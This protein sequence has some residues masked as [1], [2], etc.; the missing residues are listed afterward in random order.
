[1]SLQETAA[2]DFGDVITASP[3][4][5][6]HAKP[7]WFDLGP[8]PLTLRLLAIQVVL[9]GVIVALYQR[10]GLSVAWDTFTFLIPLPIILFVLWSYFFLVPGRPR[11]WRI[12]ETLFIYL[13]LHLLTQIVITGQYAAGALNR[14]TIDP[15]LAAADAMLG[16]HVPSMAEWTRAH[17]VVNT[18]LLYAYESF[19]PQ[20]LLTIP[21][22]GLVLSDRRA[23]MEYAFHFHFC[24][25]V[26]LVCF[27]L[28]P[29]ACAFTYY[30]F[31]STFDQARF[32]A[33]FEGIRNGTL[34]VIRFDDL[35]GLVSMPS[36]H[37]AAGIFVTWAF[38]RYRILLLPLVV[39]NAGLI[40]A[41]FMSGTHYFIDAIGTL[42]MF[43]VSIWTYRR[44]AE[45]LLATQY[46]TSRPQPSVGE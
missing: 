44:W 38:R 27:A 12:P 23:L 33:H 21:V 42:L 18:V 30:G 29:A 26:T 19:G 32:I 1:M 34:R 24:A 4:Q 10:L 31:D 39:L 11:E 20:L 9:L 2:P 5:G 22:L 41:T 16:I 35:E 8:N 45:P 40:I 28:F 43:A 37:V 46:Q 15:L 6:K 7:R 17:P 25:I 36:F 3:A 13:L 14:P